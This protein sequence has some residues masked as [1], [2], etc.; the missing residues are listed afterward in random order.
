MHLGPLRSVFLVKSIFYPIYL[1]FLLVLIILFLSNECALPSLYLQIFFLCFN[2]LHCASCYF[3]I[4]IIIFSFNI[5]IA[6]NVFVILTPRVL[7]ALHKKLLGNFMLISNSQVMT[8]YLV[9][10]VPS[11]LFSISI[12]LCLKQILL[13]TQMLQHATI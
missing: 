7:F 1:C 12:T 3:C 13:I 4:S 11:F 8:L 10:I 6:T 2:G 5:S 9:T